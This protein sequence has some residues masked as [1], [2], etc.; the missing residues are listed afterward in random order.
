MCCR[1][2]LAI[3]LPYG[4]CDGDR[5]GAVADRLRAIDHQVHDDLLHLAGIGLHGRQ[6]ARRD[7]S[8]SLHHLGIG[9]LQQVRDVVHQR[10]KG[11]T[12]STTN[13]PLPQYASSCC[14]RSAARSLACTTF[15]MQRRCLRVGRQEFEREAGVAQNAR[16]QV[17]EVVR[18]AAGEQ[19]DALQF[20]RSPELLFE[21]PALGD[22][23]PDTDDPRR[24]PFG[25]AD[26]FALAG[27]PTN[28]AVRPGHAELALEVRLLL[29]RPG[30]AFEEAARSSG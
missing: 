17:V 24:L 11:P 25:I 27:H 1:I 9:R 2:S 19:S 4:P 15:S 21:L 13:R 30:G 26:H 12:G 7:S 14:V 8:R 20:L 6:I 29:D 28:R 5:A 22:V 16:Q 18:D 3:Q 10:A 23:H